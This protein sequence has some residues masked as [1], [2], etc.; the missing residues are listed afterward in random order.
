MAVGCSVVTSCNP[1]WV[2]VLCVIKAT[3]KRS[4]YL[5]ELLPVRVTNTSEEQTRSVHG[6]A[7]QDVKCGSK[8]FAFGS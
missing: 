1:M 7:G 3:R 6:L 8:E 5:R 2:R 4:N